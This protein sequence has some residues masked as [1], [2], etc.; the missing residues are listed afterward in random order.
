MRDFKSNNKSRGNRS[1]G[2]GGN[3]DRRPLEMHD[4]TCDK[5][6]NKC[7]VPF[8]PSGNKP[9]LCSNCFKNEGDSG[10]RNNSSS[11]GISQEQYKEL[12]TKLDKILGILEKE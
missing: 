7:Q 3:R 5:C 12:N 4:A 11:A 1:G 2:F 6:K 9:V 8:K 10:S